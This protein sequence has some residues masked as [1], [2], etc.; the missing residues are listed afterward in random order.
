MLTVDITG[1]GEISEAF[2]KLV[3]KVQA[4]SLT[5]LAKAVHDDVEQAIDRH[6]KEGELIQ[7][8]R[9][10]K[11]RDAH[12]VFNDLQRAPHAEHVHWGTKPH[13]I[14]ARNKKAL[15]FVGKDGNFWMF[16]GPKLP[17]ERALIAKWRD[18]KAPG[19]RLVFRWPMHPGYKGD[20]WFVDA[21][22]AA[23]Q[24]FARII[25]QL[26]QEPL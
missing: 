11:G 25:Q 1:L 19:T 2:A 7:S 22:R 26:R 18:K 10:V 4:K 17:Q 21:H 9:W 14:K 23:P 16:F 3:P 6:T 12:Y 13:L 24:H 15:R 8:L 5:R 20:P